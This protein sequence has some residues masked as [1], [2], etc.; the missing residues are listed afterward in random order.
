MSETTL[1]PGHDDGL[2]APA[3]EPMDGG[4]R[5]PVPY[6]DRAMNGSHEPSAEQPDEHAGAQPRVHRVSAHV[7]GV[8]GYSN[9]ELLVLPGELR[10]RLGGFV[11]RMFAP[12][13]HGETLAFR[14]RDLT[15]ARVRW[16]LPWRRAALLLPSTEH[17][18]L[19][20]LSRTA[21]DALVGDLTASGFRVSEVPVGY[22][23]A[24]EALFE[25]LSWQQVSDRRRRP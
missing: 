8:N 11:A 18:A 14:S 22:F 23:G 19:L 10:L 16:E 7:D 1:V 20:P 6:G 2:P 9:C 3:S 4:D 5:V 25:D 24:A 15:M 13:M 17:R 21:A 12:R